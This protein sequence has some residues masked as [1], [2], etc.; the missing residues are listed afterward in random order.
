[1]VQVFYQADENDMIDF[2]NVGLVYRD[3][4][5]VAI[6]LHHYVSLILNAAIE[7]ENSINLALEKVY[8]K[9]AH[10]VSTVKGPQGF[11][12][13][14]SNKEQAITG[15]G[16]MGFFSMAKDA[17]CKLSDLKLEIIFNEKVQSIKKKYLDIE[18]FID[19]MK[20]CKI[21]QS[22][23]DFKK[24]SEPTPQITETKVEE[25]KERQFIPLETDKIEDDDEI[26]DSDSISEEST[27]R[28]IQNKQREIDKLRQHSKL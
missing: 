28:I 12:K 26:S 20:D 18:T 17:N 19:L 27:Q 23:D 21:V 9:Y 6:P 3:Q 22:L 4:I 10:V 5:E 1:M 24:K 16:R 25:S 8:H 2:N 14:K 13:G 11:L 15:I 7:V